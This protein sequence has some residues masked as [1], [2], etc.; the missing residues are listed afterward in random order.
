MVHYN[1]PWKL[2]A[3]LYALFINSSNKIVIIKKYLNFTVFQSQKLITIHNML[4]LYL[5][6]AYYLYI[7]WNPNEMGNNEIMIWIRQKKS[8]VI[9]KNRNILL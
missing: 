1:I 7:F 5:M 8:Y 6:Y 9:V 2:L 4:I 3:I